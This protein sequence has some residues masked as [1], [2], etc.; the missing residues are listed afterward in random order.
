MEFLTEALDLVLGQ[1]FLL[2]A[3]SGVF[4]IALG[5]FLPQ[6]KRDQL[7]VSAIV[8]FGLFN[9]ILVVFASIW[10]SY[11]NASVPSPYLVSRQVTA[12]ISKE[13]N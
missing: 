4:A 2:I 6:Y 7:D 9:S 10:L 13:G 8:K 11:V 1:K 3:S 12:A 5:S